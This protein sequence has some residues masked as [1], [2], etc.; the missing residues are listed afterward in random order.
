[1]VAECGCTQAFSV[2]TT[3]IGLLGGW[4]LVVGSRVLLLCCKALSASGVY[5]LTVDELRQ[6]CSERGL[7]TSAPVPN[8]I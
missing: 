8:V 1:M 2:V 5:R 7:D 3:A 4:V 6:V